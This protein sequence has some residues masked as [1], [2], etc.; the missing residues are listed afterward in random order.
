VSDLEEIGIHEIASR[1]ICPDA[2]TSCANLTTESGIKWQN[3]EADYGN[4]PSQL[5]FADRILTITNYESSL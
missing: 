5:Y 4:S 2:T 1:I 3:S